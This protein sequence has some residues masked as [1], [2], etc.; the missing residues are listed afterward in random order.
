MSVQPKLFLNLFEKQHEFKKA[1]NLECVLKCEGEILAVEIDNT[2]V[3]GASEAASEGLVDGYDMPPIDTWFYHAE[4]DN[5]MILFAWIPK[6]F[7]WFADEAIAVNVVDML[8]WFKDWY[9]ADY[10][11]VMQ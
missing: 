7:K 5:G 6:E 9:P 1:L 2:V 8:R 11:R 10:R 3:D 4:G